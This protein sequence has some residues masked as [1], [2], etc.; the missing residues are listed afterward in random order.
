M[1]VSNSRLGKNSCEFKIINL[2]FAVEIFCTIVQKYVKKKTD[3]IERNENY[4][5]NKNR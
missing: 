2:Y 1:D 5:K 4:E 3:E